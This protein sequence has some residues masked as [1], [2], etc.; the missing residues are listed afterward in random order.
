MAVTLNT[1]CVRVPVLSK[2]MVSTLL[3]ASKKL[4][5]LTKIP[6]LDAP[7][8]PPKKLSGIE[9]TSA[10]GHETT[11]KTSARLNHSLSKASSINKGG[12]KAKSA[13]EITTN[14]V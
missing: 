7:P 9:T 6:F 5:P 12:K 8:I 13:A 10:H 2:T 11:K 14:G 1:P 3:S 4:P